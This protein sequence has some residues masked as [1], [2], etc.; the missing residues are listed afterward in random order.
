MPHIVSLPDNRLRRGRVVSTRNALCIVL[1][2]QG[3]RVALVPIH[4]SPENSHRADVHPS[5]IDAYTL[6]LS[7]HD[8]VRCR[9]F[10]LPHNAV[11][12]IGKIVPNTL[13]TRVWR[14]ACKELHSQNWEDGNR[15]EMWG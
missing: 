14:A 15:S 4:K 8:V 10:I 3:N 2:R 7:A 1:K 5:W 11:N 9:A 13:M 6:G 12:S